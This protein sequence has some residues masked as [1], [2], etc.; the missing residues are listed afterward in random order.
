MA[1]RL[2][3]LSPYAIASAV[4]ALST[5]IAY[6]AEP[7]SELGDLAV[8]HLLAIVLVSTKFSLRVSVFACFLS[9]LSLDFIFI[10]PR[11]EF[12][13]TDAKGGLTFV[14]MMVVACVI[15]SLTARLR[16]EE[17]VARA[18]SGASRGALSTSRGFVDRERPTPTGS[19][20]LATP[21]APPVGQ[22]L[23]LTRYARGLAGTARSRRVI[24]SSPNEPGLAV[25]SLRI[26][27]RKVPRS[28]RRSPG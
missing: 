21:R 7:Y 5:A 15:S 27:R 18:C 28:G 24:C 20:Y 23:D 26:V 12:A 19:D 25:S 17:Q 14:A 13:W 10:P 4:V 3:R 11:F 8:V 9:I 6:A 1:A 16:R 2:H 22:G